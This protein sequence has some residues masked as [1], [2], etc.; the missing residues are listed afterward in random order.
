MRLTSHCAYHPSREAGQRCRS[1]GKWLCDRCVRPIRGHIYC[2]LKCRLHDLGKRST[3]RLVAVL[4]APIPPLLAAPVIVVA[5]LAAG[6]WIVALGVRLSSLAE[7]PASVAGGPP[8]AVAD[9][10]RADDGVKIEIQGSPGANVL[11]IVDSIPTRVL[12]LDD[13]GRASVDEVALATASSVEIAVLA[14]PPEPVPTPPTPLAASTATGTPPSTATSTPTAIAVPTTTPTA[15]PAPVRSPSRAAQRPTVPPEASPI[16]SRPGRRSIGK[17]AGPSPPV[18]H[19]VT[20]AGNRIAVTFDGNA[21][22]NGTA[23]LLDLLQ[24]LDLDITLFVTGGF[25]ERYPTLVRRALLAGHEVGNHTYSHP[26]LTTYADNH[27]HILLP[28]VTKAW[29]QDQLKQTEAA[30]RE[31]T[32]RPLAPVWRA[33]YG[34]ENSTLRAWALELGYLHVRWSSLEGASLDARDWVADEHSKLFQNSRKMMDRL[35]GFPHLEGGIVLM[36]LA[37]ERSEPPWSELPR[38]VRELKRRNVSPVKISELLEAS[39]T[40]RPWIERARKNHDMNFP[41]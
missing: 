25:V 33:P 23:E 21:S 27:R 19:L 35:L 8:F 32:G 6:S 13:A 7:A 22:S 28:N 11:I 37:T 17:K 1:C 16:P 41:E 2:G 38:F 18:L 29:F 40:W 14:A 10:V 31:A 34:E 15:T 5:A 36:H 24:E 20:D 3:S 4:R 39:P 12:T 9:M 30:F 26:H